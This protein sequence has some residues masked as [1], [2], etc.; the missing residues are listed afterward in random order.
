[1]QLPKHIADRIHQVVATTRQVG[2]G[3]IDE[4]AA[5]Y[6][7]VALMGTLGCIWL[8]RPDGTLWE[9]DD[10]FG[11]PL[12]PLA[13]EWQWGAIRC[14]VERLPWLADA[15]PRRPMGA[16]DCPQCRGTGTFP[17]ERGSAGVLCDRCCSRGWLA[18]V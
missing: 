14:G 1:M 11:R 13:P 10:D 15:L 2:G 18:P 9:V 5:K 8:L 7:G 3:N 6:G 16:T 4:E 12:A 17:P